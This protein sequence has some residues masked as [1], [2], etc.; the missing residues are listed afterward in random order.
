MNKL[1]KEVREHFPDDTRDVLLCQRNGKP[2]V[3]Q[4]PRLNDHPVRENG[5]V[6]SADLN[7]EGGD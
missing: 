7:I 4:Q 5:H 2:A 3:G 1:L 6:R